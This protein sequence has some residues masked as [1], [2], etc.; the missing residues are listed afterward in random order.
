M[1]FDQRQVLAQSSFESCWRFHAREEN[2][3]MNEILK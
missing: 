1:T 2:R 3:E